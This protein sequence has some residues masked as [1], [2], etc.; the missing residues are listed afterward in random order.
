MVMAHDVPIRCGDVLVHPRELIVADYD[1]IVAVPREV[2]KTVLVKA[3][4]KVGKE[5]IS[6]KELLEGKKL[7]EVYDKYGVL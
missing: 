6:R 1:G 5:N 4:E 3:H 7:R 2:E